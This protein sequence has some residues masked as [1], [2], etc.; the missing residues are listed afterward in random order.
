MPQ[1]NKVQ[2]TQYPSRILD[3]YSLAGLL[4]KK[5]RCRTMCMCWNDD[6]KDGRWRHLEAGGRL[7]AAAA[8]AVRDTGAEAA[9][10]A[11]DAGE[12]ERG[13]HRGDDQPEPPH[14]PT[15]V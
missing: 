8:E 4:I 12:D 5:T 11:A 15:L 10:D 2:L 6:D 13:R 7:S 9:A 14:R 1:N 3:G